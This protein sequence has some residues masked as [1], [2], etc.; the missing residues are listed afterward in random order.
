MAT[1][2]DYGTW[3]GHNG[4]AETGVY[5]TVFAYLGEF[6]GE[7]E[8]T[9]LVEAFR[10][11]VQKALPE[12]VTIHGDYFYGPWPLDREKLADIGPAIESVD[13]AALVSEFEKRGETDLPYIEPKSNRRWEDRE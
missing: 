6:A 12:G 13:L 1:T 9:P 3:N 7:Y 11:A 5:E 4:G 2:T 8:I 10:G